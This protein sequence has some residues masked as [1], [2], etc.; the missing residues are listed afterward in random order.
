MEILGHRNVD[1]HLA[2]KHPTTPPGDES[3]NW[4]MTPNVVLQPCHTVCL[5]GEVPA[6][7]QQPAAWQDMSSEALC[8]NPVDQVDVMKTQGVESGKQLA[9]QL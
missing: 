4:A 6:P 5:Q 7:W 2:W 1:I 8:T 3:H 9:K